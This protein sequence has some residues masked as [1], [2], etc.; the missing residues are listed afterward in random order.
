[1]LRIGN[2]IDIHNLEF[3]ENSKQKLGGCLF[4]TNWKVV[5]HSDGDVIFHALAESI[6]GALGLGDLG[7]H[8]SDKDPKNKNLDSLKILDFAI[9]Q[10][11][12]GDWQIQNID[13]TVICELIYF[14]DKKQQIKSFLQQYLNCE[15][16]NIKA[17]RFEENDCKKIVCQSTIL[18][19]KFGLKNSI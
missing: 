10:L 6:L 7:E 12:K 19:S 9:S 13:L 17:T 11:K 15:F 4:D 18:L 16:I 3:C 2:S 5:A 14:K 8:F 1:M